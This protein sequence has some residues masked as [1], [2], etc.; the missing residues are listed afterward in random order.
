MEIRLDRG[1]RDV[2]GALVRRLARL[3]LL[4][5]LLAPPQ[6]GAQAQA[7][8]GPHAPVAPAVPSVALDMALPSALSV[9]ATAR[10]C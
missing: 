1:R 9:E 5:L 6:Q 3:V 7:E 4:L 8:R 2:I 10:D